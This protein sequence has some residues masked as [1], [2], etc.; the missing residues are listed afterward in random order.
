MKSRLLPYIAAL[1]TVALIAS[2]TL[3]LTRT[4]EAFEAP[5][6]PHGMPADFTRVA[7][8]ISLQ[9][10]LEIAKENGFTVYLPTWLPD[11]MELTAV[12]FKYG[13]Y[14]IAIVVYDSHGEEDPYLAEF[15]I[16]IIPTPCLP[17]TPTE[18]SIVLEVNGWQVIIKKAHLTVPREIAKFGEYALVAD[19]YIDGVWYSICAPTLTVE[20]VIAIIQSMKPAEA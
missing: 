6:V 5:T 7:E 3:T 11:D 9:E 10:F 19:V 14:P 13:L 4:P 17:V 20:E 18:D 1:I 15:S 12:W 2:L 8:E 16:Q